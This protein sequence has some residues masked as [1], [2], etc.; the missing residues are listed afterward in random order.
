MIDHD[1]GGDKGLSGFGQLHV[2]TLG[3]VRIELSGRDDDVIALD[4]VVLTRGTDARSLGKQR[5][6]TLADR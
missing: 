2:D 6:S 3:E 5:G 4:P 1:I